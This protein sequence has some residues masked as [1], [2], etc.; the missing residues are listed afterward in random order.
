MTSF[1]V[2]AEGV[3]DYEVIR[4][5]LLGA[6]EPQKPQRP[7]IHRIFPPEDASNRGGWT[8]EKKWLL[9]REHLSALQHHDYLV[10]HIDTDVCDQAGFDIA[11]QES[12]RALDPTELRGRVI[13][14]LREWMG[15]ETR[16]HWDKVIF[17]V[18]VNEIECWL[19]PLLATTPA[20]AT[21]TTGCLKAANTALGRLSRS[22]LSKASG[23]K[24]VDAYRQESRPYQ[25]F[26]ALQS[27]GRRNPSLAA[28]L[29]DLAGRSITLTPT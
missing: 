27:S 9:D 18:S 21:K 14:R 8:V 22:R 11:R 7:F 10:I 5:I 25:K 15:P 26:P 23:E 29:D 24:S 3:T 12:G 20:G 16:P 28:F 4:N 2:I 6:F 17:A 1:G 19:L 13:A